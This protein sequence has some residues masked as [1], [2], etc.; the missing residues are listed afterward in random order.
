V[1]HKTHTPRVDITV[2]A[3]AIYAQM[4]E[5]GGLLKKSDLAA[6]LRELIL[7]RASQINGCA[8]CVDMHVREAQAQGITSDRLHQLSVWRDSP[9][10]SEAERAALALTEAATHIAQNGISDALYAEVRRYYTEEQ[11]VQ[12]LAL[13][14]VINSWNRLMIGTGAV[15]PRRE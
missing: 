6:D 5:F 10:F 15:P 2:V 1:A 9:D 4:R 8:F 12:M 13:I 7:I 3:P 14:C 11:Y